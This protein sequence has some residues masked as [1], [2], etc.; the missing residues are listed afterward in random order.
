MTVLPLRPIE[1][2]AQRARATLVDRPV[3]SA[4]RFVALARRAPSRSHAAVDDP[5][6]DWAGTGPVLLVG[7][8]CAT[9]LMLGPMRRWLEQLGYDVTTH[10]LG[11][12][13]GCAGE[14]VD[15]VE[16]RLRALADEHGRPVRVVAH[17]RGG[18][19][20]RAAVRRAAP[21]TESLVTLGTPLDLYG[22]NPLLIAQAAA[23]ALAGTLGAP[24][25]ARLAC[26]YGP[27]CAEFRDELRA[28][29]PVPLTAVYS[30]EDR[31]VRWTAAHDPGVRSLEVPGGHLGL[32]V[33]PPALC[34]V[35]EA[36]AA[37]A[38]AE[39]AAA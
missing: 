8:F 11:A 14:C 17:S 26:L 31:M 32:L 23:V 1:A 13:L 38:Q 39:R 28:P 30:R 15:A 21:Q 18:Q 5:P 16:E 35:A 9:D 22:V 36:L 3:A 12:G 7:G 27:C 10:T 37:G 2:L 29:V 19:F 33:D 4:S 20:A 34:V 24:G 25:L 6:P